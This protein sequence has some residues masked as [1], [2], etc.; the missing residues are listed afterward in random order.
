MREDRKNQRTEVDLKKREEESK[1][2]PKPKN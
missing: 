1:A 2:D